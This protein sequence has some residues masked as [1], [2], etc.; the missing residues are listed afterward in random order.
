MPVTSFPLY[1]KYATSFSKMD[2]F[3]KRDREQD[4]PLLKYYIVSSDRIY[5]WKN[6][7]YNGYT[8]LQEEIISAT[9]L[10]EFSLCD[11]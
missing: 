1:V 2:G 9:T 7:R 11:N 6:S 10:K 5:E 4:W 3:W 8:T